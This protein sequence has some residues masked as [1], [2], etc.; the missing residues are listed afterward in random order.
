MARI[1]EVRRAKAEEDGHRTA[2][3]AL[4]LE[5]IGAVPRAHLSPSHVAASAAHQL[6]W[7]ETFSGST[8]SSVASAAEGQFRLAARFSAVV[9]LKYVGR[10]SLHCVV[11]FTQQGI[12]RHLKRFHFSFLKIEILLYCT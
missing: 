1:A 4:V 12:L 10:F 3:A 2:V 11:R 5:V 9:S 7:I 8:D 6:G